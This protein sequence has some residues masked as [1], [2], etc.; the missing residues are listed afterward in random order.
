MAFY[1]LLKVREIVTGSS[2]DS[3]QDSLID[4]K[5]KEADQKLADRLFYTL[6]YNAKVKSL[7]VVDIANG[8]INGAAVPVHI[9]D[10]ASNLAAS[11]CMKYLRLYE[12]AK[13]YKQEFEETI[14]AYIA[15]LESEGTDHPMALI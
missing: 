6:S 4:S 1:N 15:K 13:E 2:G 3:S 14:M 5:G 9:S 7:P 10:A 11:L 12:G 8:Q